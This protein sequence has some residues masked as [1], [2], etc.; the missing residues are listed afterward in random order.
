MVNFHGF[1]LLFFLIIYCRSVGRL[2]IM[3]FASHRG[4][5]F[6]VVF[7]VLFLFACLFVCFFSY[8]H[9]FIFTSRPSFLKL[10][11]AVSFN[12]QVLKVFITSLV[13]RGD[14]I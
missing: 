4:T 11:F 6:N 3:L 5:L 7:D 8:N 10:L 12:Q 2:T 1:D 13:H 14:F 9:L